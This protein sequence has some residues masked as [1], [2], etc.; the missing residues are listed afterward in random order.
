MKEEGNVIA[1][2]LDGTI[3]EF[4]WK[5]WVKERMNY[6][7][8]PIPF[9]VDALQ[10]L[11]RMGNIIVIHTSRINP[12]VHNE[13]TFEQLCERVKSA[14]AKHNIPYDHLWTGVGKPIA[15]FYIDDKAVR[16]INWDQA[17]HEIKERKK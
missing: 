9:A 14:L 6:F 15:D 2:D 5:R 8:E 11:R 3:L 7:G 10:L 17:I 12:A 1:V 13:Y 16:F 4:D